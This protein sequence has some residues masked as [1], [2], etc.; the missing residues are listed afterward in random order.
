MIDTSQYEYIEEDHG[1]YH[2]EDTRITI[3]D[4]IHC[5]SIESTTQQ[6]LSENWDVPIESIQ[7]AVDIHEKN[8]DELARC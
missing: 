2:I 5:L 4:V 3:E 7:E 8:E 6:N 1:D